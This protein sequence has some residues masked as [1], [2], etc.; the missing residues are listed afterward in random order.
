LREI[1]P[2]RQTAYSKVISFLL[3]SGPFLHA[4][5]SQVLIGPGA[6]CAVNDFRTNTRTESNVRERDCD[7]EV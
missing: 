5:H 1:F 7:R 3:G 4:F 2:A 6:R